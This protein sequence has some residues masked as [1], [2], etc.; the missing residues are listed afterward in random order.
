MSLKAE[1][2]R[3]QDAQRWDGFCRTSGNATF[4]HSRR[5]LAYHGERFRDAS[6]LLSDDG[7][8][9]GLLPAAVDPKDPALV[10]S[11]PGATFGGLV[12]D[13]WLSGERMLEAVDCLKAHYA[14]AGFSRLRYRPVPYIHALQPAQD[15][16]YA[17]FRAGA[18]RQ[19][20]DLSSAIDLAHRR[21]PSERRR[22]GLKKALKA[23]QVSADPGLLAG[24]YAVIE[25]VLDRKHDAKPVHSL[26][27]LSALQALFPVEIQVRCAL[28][29]GTVQAGTVLF[30]S[31]ACWHVQYV[32]ASEAAYDASALDAVF[33]SAIEEARAAGA[34]YFDFGTSNED[35]GRVLNHSLYRYKAEFGGGGVAYE[36]YDLDLT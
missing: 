25:G 24:L 22:R 10:H 5:F 32:G 26:A 9:V 13:G 17:L 14:A 15:D 12:H 8:L 23:V 19:R 4:L 29:G 18:Q 21:T 6:L 34:R 7:T 36:S 31:P 33:E 35:Q 2:Y 20:C 30:S 27:E 11:H 16:L 3:P 1:A 28:I